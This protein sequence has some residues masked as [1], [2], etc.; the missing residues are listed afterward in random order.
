MRL[1]QQSESRS[2]ASAPMTH[3]GDVFVPLPWFQARYRKELA[4]QRNAPSL[5]LVENLLKDNTDGCALTTLVHFYCSQA[6]RL[7]GGTKTPL[8]MWPH[9]HDLT[10]HALFYCDVSQKK[11]N[12][13]RIKSVQFRWAN[14]N[15]FQSQQDNT[16]DTLCSHYNHTSEQGASDKEYIYYQFALLLRG[17]IV[18]WIYKKKVSNVNENKSCL[19]S[20]LLKEVCYSFQRAKL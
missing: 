5:P 20:S 8:G 2:Y 1:Q 10:S 16:K 7:E 14:H 15:D 11:V 9:P 17:H 19:C 18:L 13:R 6:V 3:V 12:R 4:Q